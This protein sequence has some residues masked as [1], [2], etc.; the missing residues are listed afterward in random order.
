MAEKGDQQPRSLSIAYLQPVGGNDMMASAIQNLEAK[1]EKMEAV[2][3]PCAAAY[4]VMNAETGS[5]SLQEL[6]AFSTAE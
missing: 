4:Q 1:R 5:G 3:G 2:Y 6:I